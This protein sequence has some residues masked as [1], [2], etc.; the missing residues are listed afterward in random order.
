VRRARR[1][2]AEGWGGSGC[3]GWAAGGLAELLG[4]VRS[5][6]PPALGCC[7]GHGRM[8]VSAGAAVQRHGCSRTPA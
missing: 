7:S 2:A 5:L 1:A 3:L 4:A 6:G 8:L